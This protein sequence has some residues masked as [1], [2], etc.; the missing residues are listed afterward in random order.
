M[1]GACAKATINA[2]EVK[3]VMVSDKTSAATVAAIRAAA[4]DALRLMPSGTAFSCDWEL[5]SG[6][7][8]ST[9]PF[10]ITRCSPPV[11]CDSLAEPS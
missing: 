2:A 4:G 1:P 7:Q 6:A 5:M 9:V 10:A 8:S 3:A 11:P